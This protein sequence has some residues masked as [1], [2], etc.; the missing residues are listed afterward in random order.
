MS[1]IL[2]V[3]NI[4]YSKEE[5]DIQNTKK[6]DAISDFRKLFGITKKDLT[7]D[8]IKKLLKKHNNDK[9]KAYKDIKSKL[10]KKK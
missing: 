4:N 9:N 2:N 1:N 8:E 10:S 5:K 7:D 3:F 6:I